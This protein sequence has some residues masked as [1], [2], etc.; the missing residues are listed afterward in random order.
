MMDEAQP[1]FSP[2]DYR[3]IM[4]MIDLALRGHGLALDLA[5]VKSIADKV[6]SVADSQAALDR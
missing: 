1:S 6:Q 2:Q 4:Q 5:V 3:T